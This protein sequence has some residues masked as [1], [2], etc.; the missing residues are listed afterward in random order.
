[1]Y[2]LIGSVHGGI[3]ATLLDACSGCAVHTTLPAEGGYTTTD[4]QRGRRDRARRRAR[5][6]AHPTRR[7]AKSR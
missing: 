1:M 2:N 5:G 4:L 6:L 3:A 7:A